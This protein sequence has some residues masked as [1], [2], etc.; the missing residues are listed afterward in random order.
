[1]KINIKSE[2]F[3]EENPQMASLHAALVDYYPYTQNVH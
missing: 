2:I 3:F 1:M